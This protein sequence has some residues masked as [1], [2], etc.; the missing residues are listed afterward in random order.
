[1]IKLLSPALALLISSQCAN[2]ATYYVDAARGN[3]AW[4]GNLAD[5]GGAPASNGPWQSLARVA[6]ASLQAGDT[7]ALRCGST[8]SETLKISASGTTTAPIAVRPYPGPCAATPPAIDGYTHVANAQWTRQ[9]AFVYRLPAQFDVVSSQ[10]EQGPGPWRIWSPAADAQLSAQAGCGPQ[11]AACLQAT[12]GRGTMPTVIYGPTFRM[13]GG[14]PY[15][16]R[17]SFKAA[18][19]VRLR[20]YVRRAVAPYDV[21]GVSGTYIGNGAWQSVSAPFK[22]MAALDNA[23]L[24]LDLPSDG[25]SASLHDP[26]IEQQISG[27]PFSA[28]LGST[29]LDRAHFPSRGY[30]KLEPTSP[31][32]R[33]AADSDVVALPN[34]G[35]GSTYVTHGTNFVLPPGATLRPGTTIR[36]RTTAWII[37]ERKIVGVSGNRLLLDRP[38]SYPLKVGWGYYLVGEPWMLDAPDEWHYDEASGSVLVRSATDAPPPGLLSL[39]TLDTCVDVSGT[40]NVRI[41]GLQLTGCRNG[42]VATASTGASLRNSRM[43]DIARNGVLA[44][45]SRNLQVIGN[46]IERTGEHAVLGADASPGSVSTGM[47]V[48]DNVVIEAGVV[49]K[50]GATIALPVQ[51][52]GAV[53]SGQASSVLNNSITATGYHGIRALGNSRVS[54]NTLVSA[55]LVL[56][57]CGAI[58]VFGG[59]TTSQGSRIESNVVRDVLGGLNGKPPGSTPQGQGIF[60]DDHAHDVAIVG[61]TVSEAESGVFLHNAYANTVQGNILYGNRKH[62][63]WLMEDTNRLDPNGDMRNNVIVDNQFFSTSPSAAVGQLSTIKNT[64]R[65]ATYDRNRYSALISKRVVAEDWPTGS[66]AFPFENWQTAVTPSGVV[67]NMEPNGAVVNALGYAGFRVLGGNLVQGPMVA[68]PGKWTPWSEQLPM[69]TGQS[70]ACG[71]QTC[72]EVTAGASSSLAAT[73]PFS[74]VAGNWYRVTADVR[75]QNPNQSILMLVRRAGGGSNGWE[76]LM[77]SAE[78]ITAQTGFQRFSFTFRASQTINANDPVTQDVGARLYFDRI[79]PGNRILLANVEIVPITAADSS[80]QTR[81][82]T[83]TSGTTKSIACPDAETAPAKCSQYVNFATGAAV[84]WPLSLTAK[85]S[86]VAYTRDTSLVDSDGDGIGDE[87]DACPNTPLGAVTNAR[88]C[89]L[90]Q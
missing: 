48:S 19:G 5:P 8:W 34:G 82:L 9:S 32:L 11:G 86:I 64:S 42:L 26:A 18:A 35:S 57:D 21:V 56:D 53:L 39:G 45:A 74:V 27:A 25:S 88:G 12:S 61:N 80:M 52:L 37:D 31:Y 76:S 55:C 1:M 78:G 47:L 89:S 70:V 67:R 38:T 81:L 41:E 24:D 77:G 2:A 7:V 3:D 73:P 68:G 23:R 14:T 66:S 16:M 44:P 58:Y 69:A 13:T 60:L 90:T 28:T 46:R 36:I 85:A 20:A 40:Q 62:Q 33:T 54:G 17:F 4:A 79:T 65:F 71:S 59:G 72:L 15:R 63:I 6:R 51:T 84:Q 75:S 30:D 29:P 83:N 43:L 87:G 49:R 22:G 10:F 50:S